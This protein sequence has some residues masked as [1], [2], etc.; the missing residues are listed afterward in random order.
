MNKPISLCDRCDHV[1]HCY[2]EYDEGVCRK[3]R[4][5]QPTMADRIRSMD[6][7]ELARYFTEMTMRKACP[8]FGAIDCKPSCYTCWLKWLKG[9]AK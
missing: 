1:M 8:N 5:V 4:T 9:R 2:A 7:E 6:D 3:I